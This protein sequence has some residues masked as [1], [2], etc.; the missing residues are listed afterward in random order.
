MI[1]GIICGKKLNRKTKTRLPN[2]KL[3]RRTSFVGPA[4]HDPVNIAGNTDR[5]A[6]DGVVVAKNWLVRV[7]SQRD[8]GTKCSDCATHAPYL[9]FKKCL[10][11]V[12]WQKL[13]LDHC[14]QIG[15]SEI[16]WPPW[17][18]KI[19]KNSMQIISCETFLVMVRHQVYQTIQQK[20]TSNTENRI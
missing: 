9:K 1:H 18:H 11:K 17:T 8:V 20:R 19:I 7:A 13:V 15:G 14:A 2:G 3:M 12:Q 5:V 10:N 6:V 4:M 16:H